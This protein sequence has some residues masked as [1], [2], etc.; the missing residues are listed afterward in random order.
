MS[1]TALQLFNNFIESTG[2]AY[3]P[4]NEVI[5]D[6]QLHKTYSYA[7]LMGGDRGMKDMFT[8]GTEVR[9]ATFFETGNR[10]HWHQPGAT[11]NW[12][13]DQKVVHGRALCRYAIGHMAWNLQAVE[14]NLGGRTD[15]DSYFNYKNQL[16]QMAHT[17][18]WDFL[19]SSAWAKPEFEEMESLTGGAEGKGYSIPA[20][21]NEYT[22]GLFNSGPSS[23]EGTAWTTIHGL[24]PASTDKGQNRFQIQTASYSNSNTLQTSSSL[25]SIL[26]AFEKMWKKVHFEKPPTHGDAY[27]N[28][29][30]NSQQIFCSPQGQ[31]AYAS[32]LRAYQ[33]QFVIEGR[34]DP[35][36]PDPAFNFIPVKYVDALT[37][38]LLYPNNATIGSATANIAEGT[39]ATGDKRGPR[40]YWTNSNF[41]HPFFHEDYFFAR[42]GVR[43]QFNDPDTFVVP[44]RVWGNIKCTSRQRQ[45]LVSP[46]GNQFAGLY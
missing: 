36:Y 11:Q 1:G 8:G 13:Q 25:S 28:P 39:N 24:N 23:P 30:Y 42:G 27:S 45:G 21:I 2:P 38:A 18:I 5:N 22:N 31:T 4:K 14:Q 20:F 33:D 10:T 32:T 7:S 29:A 34:Q 17:D 6:A 16:E 35:A 26:G 15:H 9:F 40:F 3:S 44:I 12:T 43:E 46:S 41:L 37:T 19:E